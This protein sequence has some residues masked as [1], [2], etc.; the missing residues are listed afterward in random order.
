MNTPAGWYD[1]P[2]QP[3]WLRWWDGQQW[4]EHTQ[5][6]QTAN[7]PPPA[8]QQPDSSE[9]SASSLPASFYGPVPTDE[10][11]EQAMDS[12]SDH[13]L[14]GTIARMGD[15]SWAYCP[16]REGI[17]FNVDWSE[18]T[19]TLVIGAFDANSPWNN[20]D[21]PDAP[22]RSFFRAIALT[23]EDNN[24]DTATVI[25]AL[26]L[27]KG[28]DDYDCTHETWTILMSLC[29]GSAIADDIH[30]N[31]STV[32][33]FEPTDVRVIWIPQNLTIS[34]TNRLNNGKWE[35][36]MSNEKNNFQGALEY[37]TAMLT[38]IFPDPDDDDD[39]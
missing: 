15:E 17:Y 12:W 26:W 34:V 27:R 23:P 33:E 4:T 7:V 32:I 13:E 16:S 6:K 10:Q 25:A 38:T 31:Y 24:E 28:Y 9:Q 18:P 30:R 29:I 8:S 22:D 5:Q 36:P 2:Q 14:H 37:A 20:Q 35:L 19:A 1:S 39:D 11:L 21:T 3:G